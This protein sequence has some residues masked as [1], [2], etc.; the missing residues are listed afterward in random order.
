MQCWYL[1]LP[2]FALP[3]FSNHSPS[4]PVPCIFSSK[5]QLSAYPL[6]SSMNLL[7]ASYLAAPSSA[8]FYQYIHCPSSCPNHLSPASLILS[9]NITL[10]FLLLCLFL[11]RSNL[12]QSQRENLNICNA[13]SCLLV[14]STTKTSLQV[15]LT[16][17]QP[18]SN[19]CYYSFIMDPSFSWQLDKV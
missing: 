10:C 11:I 12:C 7:F 2:L 17:T 3:D 16:S 8:Y 6:I 19:C 9:P 4:L 14:S 15:S 18:S 5:S 1:I 13:A